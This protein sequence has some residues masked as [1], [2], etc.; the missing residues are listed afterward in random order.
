MRN[1]SQKQK[2]VSSYPEL[3]LCDNG[4]F[5]IKSNL[6]EKYEIID[7]HCHLFNGLSELFPS[8]LQK[9][10]FNPNQSLMDLSCFPYS[11]K[12]FDL[13][14]VYFT[15]CPAKLLS[16]DGIKTRI[17]LFSGALVLNYSTVD[18]IIEDMNSN[19]I[20]KAVVQQ[21][22]PK[23]KS[24]AETIDEIVRSNDRLYTFGSIHPF[25]DDISEKINSYMK[26]EIKGWKLNPHIWGVPIDC[27]ESISLLKELA[28]T[29]LPIMSCSGIGLPKEMM[30]SAIP[31]K[32]TK[33]EVLTQQLNKFEKVLSNIPDV[34]FILAHSGCYDFEYI[35]DLMMKFPN[36]YTDISVQ[37]SRN[38]KKLIDKIGSERILFGTDYPFV[39]QAFSILS[40]LR[41]TDNEKERTDIFSRNAKK[42]INL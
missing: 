32:K 16:L 8:L 31:T 9:E 38:I 41:A 3:E 24:C 28:K 19:H 10:K 33:T 36:T 29:K 25:D 17:K 40:V 22:N 11:L 13:N 23:N 26:R 35:A 15:K 21:I 30:N 42:V 37:P 2:I 1:I 6:V 4:D 18:R 39:T 34:T 27:E 20:Q 14:E 5:K 7:V 12:L